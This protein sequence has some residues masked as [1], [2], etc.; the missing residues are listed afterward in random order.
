MQPKQEASLHRYVILTNDKLP[1][2]LHYTGY[3]QLEA[4]QGTVPT[5]N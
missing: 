1:I 3:F 2:F 5:R 4:V